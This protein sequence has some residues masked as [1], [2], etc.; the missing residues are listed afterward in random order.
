MLLAAKVLGEDKPVIKQTCMVRYK[1]C[2]KRSIMEYHRGGDDSFPAEA[3]LK[4][5]FTR[6]Y[7]D[8][9]YPRLYNQ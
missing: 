8:V 9:L 5:A 7:W 3:G 2:S 1:C 6:M 4:D